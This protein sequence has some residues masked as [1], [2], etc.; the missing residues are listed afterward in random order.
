MLAQARAPMSPVACVWWCPVQIMQ[1]KCKKSCNEFQGGI[2]PRGDFSS[3]SQVEAGSD[4][5]QEGLFL[6]YFLD[7]TDPAVSLLLLL[8]P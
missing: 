5:R 7:L 6:Q 2:L 1:K 3:L 4:L 8:H